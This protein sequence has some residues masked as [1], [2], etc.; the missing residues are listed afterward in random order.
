MNSNIPAKIIV[1]LGPTAVGKSELAVKIAKEFNGEII[2]ADSRQVYRGLDI[3]TGKVTKNEMQ[4]IKHHCLDIADPKDYFTVSDWKK[5]AEQAITEIQS[6]NKL[7]IICGGTG[8][9]IS[10]LI[11]NK[12]FPEVETDREEQKKL[13]SLSAEI[14]FE[15]LVKLDPTRADGM[16]ANGESKNKRRV[17]RAILIAR[18]LGKVPESMPASAR[19]NG[20]LRRA[21]SDICT[22]VGH[23]YDFL[24][25]GLTLP[26]DELK[27]RIRKRTLERIENGM[28][29]EARN[30]HNNGL[31]Y[32]RMY[33]LGLEYKYLAEFLQDK[34]SKEKLIEEIITKDWQYVRRQKTWWRRDKSI[35]WFDGKDIQSIYG[36]INI[37]NS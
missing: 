4:G 33:E 14:L 2:S 15:T 16:R 17:A 28:I 13:E 29:E 36:F 37:H 35:R 30:L 10:A 22:D 12:D 18:S 20:E 8:Y 7:P 3:A 27:A 19:Q 6:K 31:S 26:D 5:C 1:I 24:L 34:I 23:M 21:K 9:Y 32:E 11:D 25:I